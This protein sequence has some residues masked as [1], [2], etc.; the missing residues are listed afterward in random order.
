MKKIAYSKDAL[1]T[2][3]SLPVNVRKLIVSKIELYAENPKALENNLKALKGGNGE[4]RLRVGDWRIVMT[5]NDTVV[6]VIKV[7]P[8][9]SVYH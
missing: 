5:D 4:F 7:G 2:L 1:R 3:K 8:R 9:G 6:V